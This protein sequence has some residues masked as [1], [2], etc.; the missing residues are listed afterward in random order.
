MTTW[1]DILIRARGYAGL[2]ATLVIF[3]QIVFIVFLIFTGLSVFG[4]F[5][6]PRPALLVLFGGFAASAFMLTVIAV[7]AMLMSIFSL[8]HRFFR[9]MGEDLTALSD[10]ERDALDEWTDAVNERREY[11]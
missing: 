1:D 2:A 9:D 10:E 6:E 5:G 8:L 7:W 11:E 4:V 3:G